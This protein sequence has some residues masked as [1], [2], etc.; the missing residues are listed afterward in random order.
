[1]IRPRA[2]FRGLIT[3]PSPIRS[4]QNSQVYH[5]SFFLRQTCPFVC[6]VGFS[7]RKSGQKYPLIYQ[8]WFLNA[9]AN[10]G[11]SGK[12]MVLSLHS[13]GVNFSQDEFEWCSWAVVLLLLLLIS[14]IM[15]KPLNFHNSRPFL[16]YLLPCSK[17]ASNNFQLNN[18]RWVFFSSRAVAES[19]GIWQSWAQVL[20]LLV[21]GCM[22]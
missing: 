9:S 1:M 13:D 5:L 21:L 22:A 3:Q 4:K 16:E 18:K 15:T 7:F 8:K 11:L 14:S 20:A 10:S 12:V 6:S 17:P 2:L 19:S